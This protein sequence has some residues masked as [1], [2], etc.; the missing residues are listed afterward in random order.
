MGL[1]GVGSEMCWRSVKVFTCTVKGQGDEVLLWGSIAWVWILPPSWP[2]IPWGTQE[3]RWPCRATTIRKHF[4]WSLISIDC[5]NKKHSTRI[6]TGLLDPH[7]DQEESVQLPSDIHF[8]KSQTASHLR[9]LVPLWPVNE[10]PV[11]QA[12]PGDLA[13]L[14]HPAAPAALSQQ[15]GEGF[16]LWV[17]Q[18]G[19]RQN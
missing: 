14:S 5:Y 3:I 6:Q 12:A 16:P 1:E 11:G 9:S 19:G 18:P 2:Q 17:H 4:S 10:Q 7:T 13:V 15:G 8:W